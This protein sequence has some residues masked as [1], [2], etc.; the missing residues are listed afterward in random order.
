MKLSDIN[1]R[2]S[3]DCTTVY[4]NY[5]RYYE[6][7]HDRSD[8]VMSGVHRSPKY[9]VIVA[10]L[11]TNKRDYSLRFAFVFSMFGL[12]FTAIKQCLWTLVKLTELYAFYQ[13]CILNSN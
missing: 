12:N 1:V 3:T 8:T 13:P 7:V 11:K 9:K 4:V 6:T 5:T 10:E 2:F